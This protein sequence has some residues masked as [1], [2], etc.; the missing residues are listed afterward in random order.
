MNVRLLAKRQINFLEILIIFQ[1]QIYYLNIKVYPDL[2]I[3]NK[4][5]LLEEIPDKTELEERV[6]YYMTHES[7]KSVNK[8]QKTSYVTKI[9]QLLS[10]FLNV[11]T[12]DELMEFDE[13]YIDGKF[14]PDLIDLSRSLRQK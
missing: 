12:A 1:F 2:W 5:Y 13:I 14:H 3:I 8:R 10:L 4:I 6:H 7:Y 11:F 9:K